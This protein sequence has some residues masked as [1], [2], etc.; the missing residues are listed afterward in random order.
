MPNMTP[1]ELQ[2]LAATDPEAATAIAT[3]SMAEATT[4]L[5]NATS[6][7]VDVTSA[8]VDVT[9]ALVIVGLFIGL[10]Q[11]GVV[12]YGIWKMG[13]G[14]KARAEQHREAMDAEADRHKEAMEALAAERTESERRHVQA[15]K[16]LDA[17]IR[18]T[19]PGPAPAA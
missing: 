18:N 8:L 13:E 3:V 9:I 4:A 19:A 16:A 1:A 2:T 12:F 10:L 6:S 14:N 7:L 17:L 5:V 15:M 11:V